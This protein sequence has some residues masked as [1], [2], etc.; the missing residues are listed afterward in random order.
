MIICH[1]TTA[2][3]CSRVATT[4]FEFLTLM[5]SPPPYGIF[6]ATL[7]KQKILIE[8]HKIFNPPHI[9]DSLASLPLQGKILPIDTKCLMY[10]NAFDLWSLQ[11]SLLICNDQTMPPQ[12]KILKIALPK[13]FEESSLQ[14]CT[15][16]RLCY[17]NSCILVVSLGKVKPINLQPVKC[18]K[19]G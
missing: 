9:I 15:D 11:I 3:L 19:S 7:S 10:V 14:L 4:I 18:A 1:V 13:I 16:C 5:P 12:H 2:L 8:W 17:F 6:P